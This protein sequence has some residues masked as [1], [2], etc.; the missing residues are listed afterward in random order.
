MTVEDRNEIIEWLLMW[1]IW[2]REALGELSN[3]RLLEE[4]DKYLKMR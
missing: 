3:R 2:N 4:Y 1:S